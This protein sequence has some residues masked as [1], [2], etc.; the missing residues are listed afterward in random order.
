MSSR[1]LCCLCDGF[2]C[3]LKTF[4]ENQEHFCSAYSHY[5]QRQFI[6]KIT[7]PTKASWYKGYYSH[8]EKF[9]DIS[10][11][12]SD[13]QFPFIYRASLFISLRT[14]V[15]LYARTQRNPLNLIYFFLHYGEQDIKICAVYKWDIHTLTYL[16]ARRLNKTKGVK[17]SKPKIGGIR[18]E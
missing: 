12:F 16:T 3:F 11:T 18:N 2:F 4:Y 15:H 9:S 13:S 10:G 8:L 7:A 6:Y 5:L 14:Y 1:C 17:T